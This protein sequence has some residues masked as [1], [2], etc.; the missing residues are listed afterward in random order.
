MD[1][2][3]H[4]RVGVKVSSTRIE[5][6]QKYDQTIDKHTLLRFFH[7]IHKEVESL[8]DKP[9]VIRLNSFNQKLFEIV[10]LVDHLYDRTKPFLIVI[11]GKSASLKTTLS[12]YLSEIFLGNVFHTDDFFKKP[13]ITKDPLSKFGSN[14]D[15]DKMNH[16]V[17]MPLINQS[18]V[19]YQPF[20]FKSHKH[21]ASITIPYKPFNIIEGAYSM[22]PY[23]GITPNLKLF[24][25]VGYFT[26]LKRIYKRNG[27]KRLKAFIYRW[28]PNEK[29]YI[30]ALNIREQSEFVVKF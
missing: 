30:K 19:T 1:S 14:I 29:A 8:N 5:F 18:S 25:E 15:F 20:D 12:G 13:Q 23:L 2:L 4:N 10:L 28:I 27:I 6:N 24:C 22:H 9:S 3:N 26:Q 16:S 11:D 17:V 21:M 7:V